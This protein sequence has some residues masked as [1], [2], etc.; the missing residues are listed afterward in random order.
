MLVLGNVVGNHFASGTNRR[1]TYLKLILGYISVTLRKTN[2]WD[3]TV[4]VKC[5]YYIIQNIEIIS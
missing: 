4:I 2:R 3:S 1:I 5:L